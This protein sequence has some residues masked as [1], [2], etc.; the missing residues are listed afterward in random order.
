MGSFRAGEWAAI[1][2]LIVS[3][4]LLAAEMLSTKIRIRT[5][6][7]YLNKPDRPMA[8]DLNSLG[9]II[10]GCNTVGKLVLARKGLEGTLRYKMPY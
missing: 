5:L 6:S 8:E 10:Q 1:E 4:R 7:E 9:L 3:G 2:F